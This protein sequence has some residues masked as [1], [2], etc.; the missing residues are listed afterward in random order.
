MAA[1]RGHRK[2]QA[3]GTT[4]QRL[5]GV[6]FIAAG[7]Y[8]WTPLK[9]SCLR[10]CRSPLEFVL[11]RWREGRMGAFRMGLE[12]GGY[13]LGCCWVIM[14]LLFV[15]GVMNLLWITGLTLLVLIEKLAPAGHW[16]SKAAGALLVAWGAA[17]LVGAG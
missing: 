17:T 8:Q 13:C 5:A 9:Q 2:E 14:L 4:S 15:G 1:Q 16:S 12:H 10:R 6:V 11:T 3:D 7:V